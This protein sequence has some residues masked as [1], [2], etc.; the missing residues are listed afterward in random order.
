MVP[1]TTGGVNR[2]VAALR[3][4]GL[5]M[6]NSMVMGVSGSGRTDSDSMGV[7]Q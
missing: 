5:G 4:W 7:H 3:P 1:G 2:C 6:F